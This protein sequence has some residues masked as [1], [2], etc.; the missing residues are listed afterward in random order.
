MEPVW[1]DGR[2]FTGRV[3]LV[4][5]GGGALG[6][7]TARAFGREGAKVALAYRS[8][9]PSAEAA[10]GEIRGYGG[11]A[12]ADRLELTDPASVETFVDGVVD[13][14]GAIHVLVNTAGRIDAADAVRFSEIDSA[15]WRALFDVDVFGTYLMCRAVVPH[16]QS[17]GGGSI[18]NFSGSYGN[19]VDQENMVNSVAVQ[20]CAAKGAVRGFTASLARD[21]AP[22]IRVNAIAPGPI[23]ANWEEDWDIPKEHMDEAIRMTPLKRL[24]RPEEIAETVLL[25][26]SDGGGYITGQIIQVDGGWI[27][28]G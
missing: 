18:V 14:Y 9:Q 15:A 27:M 2:R 11:E 6:G 19:G 24:G 21:L 13:R 25:L 1:N 4:T 28:T 10:V 26:A 16:M 17:S 7:A 5:G 12:Y 8:S 20:Y 22:S 23:A 3:V